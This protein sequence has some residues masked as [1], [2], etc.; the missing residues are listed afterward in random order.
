MTTY[1]RPPGAPPANLIVDTVEG[2]GYWP[3]RSLVLILRE[4][5]G[6]HCLSARF[7]IA[8][9]MAEPSA[10]AEYF[11]AVTRNTGAAWSDVLVFGPVSPSDCQ[12]A[13]VA[14]EMLTA[15]DVEIRAAVVVNRRDDEFTWAS[16]LDDVPEES[17]DQWQVLP[18]PTD[19]DRPSAWRRTRDDLVGEVTGSVPGWLRAASGDLDETH[20]DLAI[21]Q[22]LARLCD[23]DDSGDEAL[24]LAGLADLRARDTLLWEILGRPAAQWGPAADRLLGTVRRA[25]P[26]S[27]APAATVLAILRWQQGDGTRAGIAVDRALADDPDYTLAQLVDG[28][29][30]AGIT[31]SAWREGLR[32]LTREQCRRP[33]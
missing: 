25:A 4:L 22:M 14:A 31:P 20:R 9:V 19:P 8:D 29:L 28:C 27:A 18:W 2:M 33:A 17:T 24:L 6:Q 32:S 26:G 13:V 1:A 15:A 23:G 30:R 3:A 11:E 12:V 7:D 5:S 16:L 21:S 10:W